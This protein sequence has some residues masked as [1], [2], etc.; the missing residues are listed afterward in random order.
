M[1]RRTQ[2]PAV[3]FKAITTLMGRNTTIVQVGNSEGN[4]SQE[5]ILVLINRS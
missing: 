5:A 2:M 1:A 4:T 3:D